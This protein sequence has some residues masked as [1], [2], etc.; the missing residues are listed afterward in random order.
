MHYIEFSILVLDGVL[1]QKVYWK[2]VEE[3]IKTEIIIF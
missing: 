3:D 1:F 2:I